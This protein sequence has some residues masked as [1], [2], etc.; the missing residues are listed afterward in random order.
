[1][2]LVI[3]GI[4]EGATTIIAASIPVLRALIREGKAPSSP[5]PVELD[6]IDD[7]IPL[8]RESRATDTATTPRTRDGSIA[9]L[10]EGDIGEVRSLPEAR[11]IGL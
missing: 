9:E 3:F 11:S 4:A 5:P 10:D 7:K 8:R 1:M 6:H 2:Q